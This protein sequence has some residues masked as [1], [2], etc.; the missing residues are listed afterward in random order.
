MVSSL[1]NPGLNRG[2]LSLS[3]SVGLG[4]SSEV[5]KIGILLSDSFVFVLED[6]I[7]VGS[8]LV[9]FQRESGRESDVLLI[10]AGGVYTFYL[11]SLLGKYWF[12]LNLEGG[13]LETE[14]S[15]KIAQ[16]FYFSLVKRQGIQS[17]KYF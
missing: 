14:T 5:A 10:E 6:D 7:V 12:F 16:I 11:K 1:C 3:I 15:R 8:C 13:G 17:I 4:E 9:S 2:D